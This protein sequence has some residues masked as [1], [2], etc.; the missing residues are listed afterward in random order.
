[1][2]SPSAPYDSPKPRFYL[3][4]AKYKHS[5]HH[6]CD[7]ATIL[8]LGSGKIET[9]A[10]L[11]SNGDKLSQTMGNEDLKVPTKELKINI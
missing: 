4:S 3:G 7:V 6:H 10:M 9:V 1:M 5:N 11:S 8:S 2:S